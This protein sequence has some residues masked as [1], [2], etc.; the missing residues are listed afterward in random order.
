MT[1]ASVGVKVIGQFVGLGEF[2][3][4]LVV[5]GAVDGGTGC[6][7]VKDKG[8]AGFVPYVFSAH[9]IKGI[10]RLQIQIVDLREIYLGRHNFTGLY[11]I[12]AAVLGQN[13]FNGVHDKPPPN[14][15]ETVYRILYTILK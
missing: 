13:L 7:M 9:L 8:R 12:A 3:H 1:Y 6:I 14:V 4:L 2:P 15:S 10:D 11:L 5:D